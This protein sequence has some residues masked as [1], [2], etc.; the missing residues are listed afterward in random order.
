M[1]TVIA[2]I[3]KMKPLKIYFKKFYYWLGWRKKR[4]YNYHRLEYVLKNLLF[5][6]ISTIAI[7]YVYHS[8]KT[9][10]FIGWAILLVALYFGIRHSFR[11]IKESG[12]WYSRQINL[13]KIILIC[14]IIALL[15]YSYQN[16]NVISDKFSEIDFKSKI[17]FNDSL[18]SNTDNSEG[19]SSS[20]GGGLISDIKNIVTVPERDYFIVEARIFSLVNEERGN[21][22]ARSLNPDNNLNNLA[23]KWSEKMIN[24]NFFEHSHYNVGENIGEVPL[25]YNVVGCGSTYSNDDLAECFVKGWIESSGHHQNMIDKSY[26]ITGIGVACDN[27]KCRATQMFS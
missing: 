11:L 5:V 13:V 3:F 24:E 16:R 8:F 4:S 17:N 20:S 25:H 15:F 6:A 19:S 21:Y 23:R 14:G 26:S 18:F 10:S 22:G 12:N 1:K 7:I 27:S 2:H 9:L